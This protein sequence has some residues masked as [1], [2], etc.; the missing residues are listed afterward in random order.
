MTFPHKGMCGGSFFAE[1]PFCQN[2][3]FV[4]GL[5]SERDVKRYVEVLSSASSEL[6]G[7]ATPTAIFRDIFSTLDYAVPQPTDGA[8]VSSDKAVSKTDISYYM[9]TTIAQG[10]GK[11]TGS[12]LSATVT[13]T[14]LLPQST[15]AGDEGDDDDGKTTTFRGPHLITLTSSSSASASSGTAPAETSSEPSS[16]VGVKAGIKGVVGVAAAMAA[17][18]ML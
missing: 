7:A 17:V 13:D 2:C 11:I 16:A 14:P 12:A 8:T 10:P 4:H 5:R 18:M 15:N 6:C 3:L 9:T 1:W